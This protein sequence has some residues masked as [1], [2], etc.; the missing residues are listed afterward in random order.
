[1]GPH[2]LDKIMRAGGS[3]AAAE[4]GTGHGFQHRIQDPLV[5][6]DQADDEKADDAG[7]HDC[8]SGRV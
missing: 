6:T 8:G 3:V 5:K 7:D 1:M 2:R 4:G